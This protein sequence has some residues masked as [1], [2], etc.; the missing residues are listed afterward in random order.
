M[1][2]LAQLRAVVPL[3]RHGWAQRHPVSA[4]KRNPDPAHST[5]GHAQ[6]PPN[7]TPTSPPTKGYLEDDAQP[8]ATLRL[9]LNALQS[10]SRQT[11]AVRLTM[12]A[13]GTPFALANTTDGP[14]TQAVLTA[15]ALA[16]TLSYATL[17][18]RFVSL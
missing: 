5:S 10:L 13:I 14:P 18:G 11:I 7:P 3:G 16:I 8:P 15:A 12:L 2:V 17:S 4:G 1:I 9:Q 6:P